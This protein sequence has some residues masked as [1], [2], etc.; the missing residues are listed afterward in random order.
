MASNN[1]F[2]VGELEAKT[3]EKTKGHIESIELSDGSRVRVPVIIANGTKPGPTVFL[4]AGAHGDEINGIRAV[5]EAMAGLDPGTLSGR[6]VGVPVQNPLTYLRRERLVTLNQLDEQNM[7]RVFPGSSTGD[8]AHRT[9]H[10]ILEDIVARA[11]CDMVVDY[12]TGATGSYCPPHSFVSTI[13]N[14]DVVERSVAAA[15]A[16]NAGIC[17]YAGG[18][19]GVYALGN[20]LHM[21]AVERGIPAF[22]CELGTAVPPDLRQSRVGVDGALRLLAHMGMIDATGREPEADIIVDGI[23]DVRAS[24]GG[25]CEYLVQPGDRLKCGQPLARI[26]NVFGEVRSIPVS[27]VDGYLVTRA[28]YGALNE[29]ERLA[30]IGYRA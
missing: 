27:P 30:R 17:I 7:H 14:A 28:F 26:L 5:I 24:A 22:G 9:A 23:A 4:G 10:L 11:E 21:V 25:V 12:H 18:S 16:F 19:A 3:G 20:M 13:G 6:V 2:R 29:G 8:V 1:I 15:A